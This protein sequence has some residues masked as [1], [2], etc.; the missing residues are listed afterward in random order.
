MEELKS[1]CVNWPKMHKLFQNKGI[2]TIINHPIDD[3][4]QYTDEELKDQNYARRVFDCVT[5]IEDIL[6]QKKQNLFIYDCS[7]ISRSAT[8]VAGYLAIY[9]KYSCWQ[10]LPKIEEHLKSCW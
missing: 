4:M 3:I 6:V 2:S 1:R 10:S 8:V 7:G 9:K 5:Q